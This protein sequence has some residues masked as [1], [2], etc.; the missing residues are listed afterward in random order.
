M[1]QLRR[2]DRMHFTG[3]RAGACGR[4]D[5]LVASPSSGTMSIRGEQA[6]QKRFWAAK[7]YF[8]WQDELLDRPLGGIVDVGP[9]RSDSGE[10]E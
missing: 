6:N 10:K 8:E 5:V 3:S 7:E 9:V 2:K 4:L 1:E